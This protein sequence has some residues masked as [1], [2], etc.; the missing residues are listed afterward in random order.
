MTFNYLF[1]TDE[2]VSNIL[3][4]GARWPQAGARL[5]FYDHCQS[6]CVSMCVRPQGHKYLVA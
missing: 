2:P 5:A 1:K 4:P 3:K 6:M